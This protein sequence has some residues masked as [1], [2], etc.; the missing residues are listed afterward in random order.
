MADQFTGDMMVR[1]MHE[2]AKIVP[3]PDKRVG[4]ISLPMGDTVLSIGPE[5]HLDEL[6]QALLSSGK[7]T[8]LKTAWLSLIDKVQSEKPD[9][10]EVAVAFTAVLRLSPPVA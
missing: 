1:L 3:C 4:G 5:V 7:Q 6:R 2:V 10:A 8:P 9:P